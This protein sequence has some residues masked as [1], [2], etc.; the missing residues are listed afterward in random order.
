MYTLY[1]ETP[2]DTSMEQAWEFIRSPANLNLITPDDMAFEIITDLPDEMTEGML[3]QYNVRIPIIGKQP[4]LSELKHIVPGRSFVDEQ[5]I[6][7]YR[8]WY[9]YHEIQPHSQGVLFIDR[10]TY[11]VPFGLLGKWAHT[12]FIRKTLNRIFRYREERF[13]ELLSNTHNRPDAKDTHRPQT[14]AQELN[15]DARM[16]SE[17]KFTFVERFTPRHRTTAV[18]PRH[19]AEG[20][21]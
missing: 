5:K 6:G 1:R 12:L 7:P 8:L 17:K 3:V 20:I 16:K 13:Q 15:P 2:V 19:G 9:H 21:D 10:I 4:W 11:E 14:A 18:R